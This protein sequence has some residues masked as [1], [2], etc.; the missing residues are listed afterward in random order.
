[1]P[2]IFVFLETHFDPQ[3]LR[4][5]RDDKSRWPSE[6]LYLFSHVVVRILPHHLLIRGAGKF[7]GYKVIRMANY[8]VGRPF[9]EKS[10]LVLFISY[11]FV[12]G[13][14]VYVHTLDGTG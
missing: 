13:S 14:S 5:F 10:R 4:P 6:L 12:D 11:E 9:R 3:S 2:L 7:P 8:A 1:M